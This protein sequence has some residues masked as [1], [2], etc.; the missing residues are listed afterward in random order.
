MPTRGNCELDSSKIWLQV[1]CKLMLRP[2]APVQVLR[3]LGRLFGLEVEGHLGLRDS[4]LG[5]VFFVDGSG[6]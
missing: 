2:G 5:L 4:G 3:Q 1:L 6:F